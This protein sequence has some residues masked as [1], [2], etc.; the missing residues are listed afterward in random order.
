MKNA[1]FP[2]YFITSTDSYIRTSHQR[3]CSACPERS[4]SQTCFPP[5]LS[6]VWRVETR[7]SPRQ[8]GMPRSHAAGNTHSCGPPVRCQYIQQRDEVLCTG[9]S[10]SIIAGTENAVPKQFLALR[11]RTYLAAG[12]CAVVHMPPLRRGAT[13]LQGALAAWPLKAVRQIIIACCSIVWRCK[14][15]P[16]RQEIFTG[17]VFSAIVP[18]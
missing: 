11:M 8:P 14:S 18:D 3:T 15:S 4:V 2:I 7:A 16:W 1:I 17:A 6:P 13:V 10:K 5:S 9:V 12:R